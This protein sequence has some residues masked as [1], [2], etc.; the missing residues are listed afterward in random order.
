MQRTVRKTVCK[1]KLGA[2]GGGA[3]KKNLQPEDKSGS[4]GDSRLAVLASGENHSSP[5]PSI[6]KEKLIALLT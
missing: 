2:Q 3:A 6:L 1:S 4:P 5:K